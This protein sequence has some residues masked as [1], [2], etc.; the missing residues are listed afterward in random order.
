MSPLT[1]GAR[2]GDPDLRETPCQ[3]V[4]IQRPASLEQ[5]GSLLRDRPEATLLAG[6]T[7]VVPEL[8]ST[9]L[10]R[11]AIHLGGV[12]QLALMGKGWC[13]ATVTLAKLI[14]NP[15]IPEMLREVAGSIGGPAI[16]NAATIGGNVAAASP[17][18]LA[19]ALLALEAEATVLYPDG[20]SPKLVPLSRAWNRRSLCLTTFRWV[21]LEEGSMSC[22]GKLAVRAACGPTIATV[23]AVG[24]AR[25]AGP[26][27]CLAAGGV[28]IRPQRLEDA[29]SAW[30]SARDGRAGAARMVGDVATREVGGRNRPDGHPA[31]AIGTLVERLVVQVGRPR[32][33]NPE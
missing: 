5:L 19:V 10:I 25:P 13:G 17:G 28:G 9:G 15:E 11:E 26:H 24:R 23:V 27:L 33:A 8:I 2:R 18:C 14:E 21:P 7:L 16:R 31:V 4:R 3:P 29:E 30:C 12:H 22:W 20:G 1:Q 32:S 6:G